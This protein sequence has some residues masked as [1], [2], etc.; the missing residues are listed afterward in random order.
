MWKLK[1]IWIGQSASKSFALAEETFNDYNT[2]FVKKENKIKE[3][4][5]F[6]KISGFDGYYISN[7]GKVYSDLGK[8]NRN[9]NR[10]VPLYEIRGR[11]T[12]S[13]YLRVYLRDKNWKRVDKYIHRLVAE[14]FME[15]PLNKKEVNHLDLDRSNNDIS[16][17]E[18]ATRAENIHYA[19]TY[20]MLSRDEKGRFINKY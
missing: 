10:R 1:N 7:D 20:G 9:R 19:M 14:H 18:W 8:G 4:N 17:L 5:K 16:N 11:K 6:V 15:N 3:N 13:G 2:D 12:K